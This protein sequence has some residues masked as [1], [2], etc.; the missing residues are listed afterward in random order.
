MMLIY[1]YI[2]SAIKKLTNWAVSGKSEIFFNK[3]LVISSK[4]LGW[5]LIILWIIGILCSG[6]KR[7]ALMIF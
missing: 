7:R 4:E 3:V 6:S 1:I 5:F 2:Y